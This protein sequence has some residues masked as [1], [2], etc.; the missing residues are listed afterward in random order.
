MITEKQKEELEQVKKGIRESTDSLRDDF[1]EV[2]DLFA[3]QIQQLELALKRVVN[4]E[5]LEEAKAAAREGLK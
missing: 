4:S 3:P 1:I 2:I 5:S